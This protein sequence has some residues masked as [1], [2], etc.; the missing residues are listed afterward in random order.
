MPGER[1]P[2]AAPPAAATRRLP[3]FGP[4]SWRARGPR[5]VGT[6]N[7]LPLRTGPLLLRHIV[8]QDAARM[9]A[10]NAEPSTALWLPSHVY[11]SREAA[12]AA[13]AFLIAAYTTPGDPRRGPYV[14]ALDHAP[15]PAGTGQLIGH[16]GFSPLEGEVEVSYAVAESMRGQG[17]GTR[18]LDAACDWACRTFALPGVVAVTAALNDAS[19]SL[20][21]RTGFT[22][23]RDET[24]RFQGTPQSVSWYRRLADR[25]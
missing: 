13:L 16:V 12:D 4:V 2:C 11:A 18:A 23:V 19:R 9:Q 7:S 6:M 22:H 1:G 5:L 3:A 8:A 15:A 21:V 20:L 24:R 25:H 10:L 14:L 17:L